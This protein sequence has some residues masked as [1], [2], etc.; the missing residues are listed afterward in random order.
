M[1]VISRSFSQSDSKQL[2]VDELD[3]LKLQILIIIPKNKIL[4]LMLKSVQG[5][6]SSGSKIWSDMS[7]YN[8][9]GHMMV[10]V[11]MTEFVIFGTVGNF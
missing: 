5:F 8:E 11:W 9:S 2:S 3:Y 10:A 7:E 4:R 6:W 1:S